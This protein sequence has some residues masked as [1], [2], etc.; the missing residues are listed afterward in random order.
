[1]AIPN[2]N[3][4]FPA[5][6]TTATK[7]QR[8][9]SAIAA[10]GL[11][12][13]FTPAVVAR[14]PRAKN[15]PMPP[16]FEP[17]K[18]DVICGLRGKQ[19]LQHVGNRRFRVTIAMNAEK[20]VK[21]PTKL[22]KSLIVIEVVDAIRNGGGNFVKKDRK[23]KQWVE[24]GDQLA[25]EKVGHALRDHISSM[26]DTKKKERSQSWVQMLQAA[27]QQQQ[28]KQQQDCPSSPGSTCSTP[29]STPGTQK[30]APTQLPPTLP[31]PFPSL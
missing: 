24:I 9:P 16:G 5:A 29:L 13:L 10:H 26:G 15:E 25:R 31:F 12:F 27:Q 7:A 30:S 23:T 21:A 20:Y 17:D 3:E 14:I 19:A 8:T 18:Y 11:P 1:M 22:D 2:S 28:Q 6:P 4:S